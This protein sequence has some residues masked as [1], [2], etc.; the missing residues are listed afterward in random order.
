MQRERGRERVSICICMIEYV[1]LFISIYCYLSIGVCTIETHPTEHQKDD[2]D[3][4]DDGSVPIYLLP[5][6][7]MNYRNQSDMY[8]VRRLLD[9]KALTQQ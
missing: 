2:D 8:Y 3:D 1:S 5:A 6:S 7:G 4:V 9:K